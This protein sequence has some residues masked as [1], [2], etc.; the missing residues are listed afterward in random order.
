[1]LIDPI[2]VL[3]VEEA[4]FAATGFAKDSHKADVHPLFG[5]RQA[6]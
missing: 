6:V 3:F 5:R 1:L 2:T 4:E